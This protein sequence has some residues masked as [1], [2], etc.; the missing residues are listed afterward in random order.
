MG[1]TKGREGAKNKN[2]KEVVLRLIST[3]LS[4]SPILLQVQI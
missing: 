3:G 2:K 4:S 1:Q